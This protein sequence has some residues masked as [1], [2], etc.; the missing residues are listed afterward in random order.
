MIKIAQSARTLKRILKLLD[1]QLRNSRTLAII[2][3]NNPDPDALASGM[4]LQTLTESLYNVRSRCFYGGM[5]NRAENEKMVK[6]LGIAVEPFVAEQVQACDRIAL[7]DTLPGRGNNPLPADQ[8]CHLIFD[9]HLHDGH[10]KKGI[11]IYSRQVGAT[12]TLLAELLIAAGVEIRTNLATALIYAI[13]TE[14]QELRREAHP[15]DRQVYL[16]LF[17]LSSVQKI[18]EIAYPRLPYSYFVTLSAAIQ[19]ALVFR[20]IM[21][22]ALE[23]VPLPE[24]VAEL[25]DFFLRYERISWVLVMGGYEGYVYFSLRTIHP[26]G[27]AFRILQKIL[28]DRIN[29]G[30]HETYAGG[31]LPRGERSFAELERQI[32]ER[33]PQI[34]GYTAVKVQWRPLL[35]GMKTNQKVF[36]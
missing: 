8:E 18:G 10:F 29:A 23:T 20:R 2:L 7:V 12:A 25:A 17:P 13:R 32:L 22:V 3:H 35:H 19:K 31:R 15:R 27:R 36:Q 28:D 34:L 5:I 4:A 14:T 21:V 16:K 6:L 11:L 33:T 24:I 30:G 9:H 26:E 1:E